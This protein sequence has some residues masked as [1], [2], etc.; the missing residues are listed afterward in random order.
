MINFGSYYG[1]ITRI[2]DYISEPSESA[3]CYKFMT[4][5]GRDG[6]IVNFLVSPTTYFVNNETMRVG[7][8][9]VGFYDLNAPVPLI[10]PPQ[11]LAIVMSKLIKGENVKVSYFDE[12][13]VSNDAKLKLNI[14]PCTRI[15]LENNQI[16]T[17]S[18]ANRDL[19]VIYGPTTRSIPAQTTPYEIIVMC[20]KS[21]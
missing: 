17:G 7:D 14:A 19:I 15:K 16:F 1:I 13:L 12:Q 3:G 5:Q 2:Y 20:P 21:Y 4:V 6:G 10:Y 9:V 18:I 8:I 11:L